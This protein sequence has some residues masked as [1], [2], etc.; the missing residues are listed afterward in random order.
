[1]LRQGGRGAP[2][3][4]SGHKIAG[5]MNYV[6]K[7]LMPGE[8]VLYAPTYH[9]VRFLPGARP[10]AT[11]ESARPRATIPAP[12]AVAEGTARP[13]LFWA[14]LAVVGI[15]VFSALWR[16]FVDSFAEFAITQHRVIKKTGFFTR[17]VRQIPLDKIQDVNVRATLWGRWLAYGDVE[18][19]TAGSD[20][21]VVFPRIVDPDQFR[22]VLFSHRHSGGTAG[23]G[24]AEGSAGSVEARLK[25]AER[26]LTSGVI[27][28]E[29]YRRKR[30]ALLDAL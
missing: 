7:N 25:E 22:N 2:A 26:L 30:A 16:W 27:T 10:N 28:E 29:E 1:M 18:L 17:D 9:W 4:R 21:T 12:G 14:A 24:V 20:S 5:A 8:E 6:V 15:G 3:L 19:Q 11:P 13:V 23:P